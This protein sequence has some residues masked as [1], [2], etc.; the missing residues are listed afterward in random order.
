MSLFSRGRQQRVSTVD[1][2]FIP[3]REGRGR[4]GVV[5]VTADTALRHSAVW[6]CLRLRANLISS[7]PLDVFR[8]LGSINVEVPKPPVLVEPGG[9]EWDYTDWMYASQVDLD[10]AGNSIGLVTERH[11]AL[12]LPARI[13][14]QPI[15]VCSV[16]QRRGEREPRYRIDGKEYDRDQVWHE[17]QYVVSGLPVG[18]SPV[19]Y[20]AWSISEYLSL[21]QFAL[22]W[23]GGGGVPKARLKNTAKTIAPNEATAVKRRFRETVETGDLFVHGKDWEYHMLQAEQAGMEWLEGRRFGLSDVARFFDC[24]ADL[25]DA[26]ISAPGT[27]TYATITQRNLQFLIMALEPAI[28]RREKNLSKLL[29]RPRFVKLNTDALLRMDPETRAKVMVEKIKARLMTPT[30]GRELDNLPPLTPEQ[31]A[32]FVRLFGAPRTAAEPT[33]VRNRLW[34]WIEGESDGDGGWETVTPMSA[35]PAR[36]EVGQ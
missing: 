4:S 19:A 20:A 29:P 6:A 27:L 36:A 17:R 9:R 12:N 32:E 21:Q 8:K 28:V 31:E 2:P 24:P 1:G 30:E 13:E 18:L 14:L 35:V 22:D 11:A 33:Q 25:I 10:R 34:P 5:S 23:F 15:G 3:P 16:I 7:F 26:A